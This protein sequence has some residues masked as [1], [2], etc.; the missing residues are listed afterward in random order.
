[1]KLKPIKYKEEWLTADGKRFVC[2]SD[3]MSHIDSSMI[4]FTV[5]KSDIERILSRLENK[6]YIPY[7]DRIYLLRAIYFCEYFKRMP[8]LLSQI[9]KLINKIDNYDKNRRN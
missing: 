2:Y 5:V 3:A 8:M 7:K 9:N 4:I 1:M 6:S